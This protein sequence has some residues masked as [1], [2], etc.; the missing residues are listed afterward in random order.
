MLIF[1]MFGLLNKIANLLIA[2]FPSKGA[3]PTIE[4]HLKL[5][6]LSII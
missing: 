3:I 5:E 2:L 6:S 1:S 4:F